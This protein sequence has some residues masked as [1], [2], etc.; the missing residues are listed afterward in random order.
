M[1]GATVGGRP[2]KVTSLTGI[3]VASAIL[4]ASMVSLATSV[5]TVSS[6]DR[7]IKWRPL[8]NRAKTESKATASR[9][10]ANITS[11]SVKALCFKCPIDPTKSVP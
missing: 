8:E 4:M 1:A 2:S 6:L 10:T 11:R 3:V 5:D 7:D 9:P